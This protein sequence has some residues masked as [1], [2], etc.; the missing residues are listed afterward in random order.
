MK[1]TQKPL[2]VC[3]F[4]AICCFVEL[5][6]VLTTATQ[7]ATYYGAYSCVWQKAENKVVYSLIL[8][9]FWAKLTDTK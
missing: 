8:F 9:C 1:A 3:L 5:P 6:G 2:N 4:G 7:A